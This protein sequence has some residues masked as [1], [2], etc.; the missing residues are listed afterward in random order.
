M[1][2][3]TNIWELFHP[4]LTTSYRV[5]GQQLL[6][7]SQHKVRTFTLVL[8]KRSTTAEHWIRL[9]SLSLTA[10]LKAAQLAS[11][12]VLLQSSVTAIS[13]RVLVQNTLLRY[14]QGNNTDA[15]WSRA[16]AD[17]QTAIAGGGRSA[18]LLQVILFS[19]NGTGDGDP[20]GLLNVTGEAIR[21][22]IALPYAH[23][24]GSTVYLGDDGLGFPPELY[25]NLTYTSSIVNATYNISNAFFQGDPLYPKSTL[26]LGPWQ[27]NESIALV[28]LTLPI[29]N[30]TSA[31]DVLGWIT[32][33]ANARMICD[34]VTSLEGLEKT[35]T[36]LLL[37]PTRPGNKLPP[38]ADDTGKGTVSEAEAGKEEI[39]FVLPPLQDASRGLRH[40][41]HAH[42]KPN[43][44]FRMQDYPAVRDAFTTAKP[45]SL[46][47]TN[48]EENRRVSVGYS[49]PSIDIVDWVLVVEQDRGEV[50]APINH[51][52][53]V[54]LACVFGTTGGLLLLLLPVAHF[55]VRPIRRLREAT[56]KTVD[57]YG[58]SSD[59]GSLHSFDSRDNNQ[60]NLSANGVNTAGAARK[61]GF[62]ANLS[63]W[64]TG[65]RRRKTKLSDHDEIHTF[66]IPGKVHDGKHIVHD[67][68]TDLT[69]TFN[70]MSEE[71][72]M[73]YERLEERVKERTR[74][75]EQS[76]KAAEAADKSKTLFIANIR[77]VCN[78][79]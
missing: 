4:I 37:G 68:L 21:G 29:I 58:F 43:T 66:R 69:R 73:Q 19:K 39:H 5:V 76:K 47:S 26:L 6:F 46:I 25:P 45:G 59:S 20:H 9:S 50:L 60:D 61:E 15:N 30:N 54:L 31:A 44:P 18:L 33:V 78:G 36:V 40:S 75:L 70:E 13:T 52:R 28:S 64:R 72:L 10:S 42:G 27:V 35:G 56:K 22:K 53:N 2:A 67:E 17:L 12:L 38:G 77:Y 63:N 51:L 71:L 8:G 14:N 34:T 16:A 62:M 41:N 3:G 1:H 79:P 7:C 65:T 48:N 49:L 23:A 11:S 57:P 74:E 32:V 55:S 24:N